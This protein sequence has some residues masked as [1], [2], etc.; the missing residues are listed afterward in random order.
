[1]NFQAKLKIYAGAA[2]VM[3]LL[4]LLGL[5]FSP[6]A[7]LH[8]SARQPL[9][10]FNPELVGRLEITQDLTVIR[11]NSVWEVHYQNQ[12]L[13]AMKERVD[14]YVKTL[15]ELSQE[16]IVRTGTGSAAEYG[17]GPETRPITGKTDAGAVLFEI[18][19][20]SG[21]PDGRRIYVQT[22][23]DGSVYLTDRRA[24][25]ALDRDIQSW[26]DNSLFLGIEDE[27]TIESLKLTGDLLLENQILKSFT[28]TRSTLD[29]QEI[30][31]NA[32]G[33]Q[34]PE[35]RT[36]I[37]RAYNSRA[38]GYASDSEWPVDFTSVSTL[39]LQTEDGSLYEVKIGTKD[40]QGRWPAETR[41]RRLWLGDWTLQDL[42]P[43]APPVVAPQ[44]P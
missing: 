15:L 3:V 10:N 41:G 11:Q 22:V 8:S 14:S 25:S 32:S 19:P 7:I 6:G 9:L 33:V 36:L 26:A 20:G 12:V 17:I 37:T 38:I 1:M 40:S 35:G 39:T 4:L 29:G 30:W 42:A 28:L 34:E 31:T 18:Y 16:R 5:W 44:E 23:K 13:P 24:A 21:A 43:P 2:G 27:S